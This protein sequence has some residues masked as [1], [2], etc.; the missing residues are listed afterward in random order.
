[1]ID[2]NLDRPMDV[3]SEEEDNMIF[4]HLILDGIVAPEQFEFYRKGIDEPMQSY[5]LKDGLRKDIGGLVLSHY[6]VLQLGYMGIKVTYYQDA[7]TSIDMS[8]LDSLLE[9][10]TT[11]REGEE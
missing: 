3:I 11:R 9:I 8:S 5:G 10:A 7:K 1:M 4:P 6:M 2:L